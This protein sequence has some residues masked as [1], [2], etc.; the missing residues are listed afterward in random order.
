MALGAVEA[1]KKAG[2]N[3][4]EWPVIFGIDG[5]KDA[6]EAVEAGTMQG[7]VYNDKEDQA[8]EMAKLAVDIFKEN[9]IES[10]DLSLG[11]YYVS[12]YQKVDESSVEKFLKPRQ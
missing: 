2:Y 1:Y 11:R 5:L 8:R 9:D 3:E 7:T 4:E 12:S 6:L 10:H